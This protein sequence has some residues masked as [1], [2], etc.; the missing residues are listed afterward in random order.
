VYWSMYRHPRDPGP[1][2]ER[3]LQGPAQP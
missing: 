1:M 3:I 2:R